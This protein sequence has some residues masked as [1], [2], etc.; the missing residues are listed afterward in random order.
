VR[1]HRY[2]GLEDSTA[3][4]AMVLGLLLVTF[5]AGLSVAALRIG[6][7]FT[8]EH[9]QEATREQAQMLAEAGVA[10]GMT[11][12][13]LGSSGSVGSRAMP[14]RY[15]DG[16]FWVSS[17]ALPG[18]RTALVAQ[19]MSNRGRAAIE[20]IVVPS[21]KAMFQAAVFSN[22]ALVLD[23]QAF[24]D[25]FDS[26]LG[27]YA[28]QL[29]ASDWN[30]VSRIG[31][32]ASN[33]DITIKSAGEVWGNATPGPTGGLYG[34]G[35]VSGWTQP[36]A[37]SITLEPVAVPAIPSTGSLVVSASTSLPA[38]DYNFTGL[39]VSTGG[40]LTV[41][42]PS[43]ILV[44]D[45]AL[46]SNSGIVFDTTNGMIELYVSGALGMAS[47][48]T[49][50]T[51]TNA[52]DVRVFLTGGPTQ[53]AIFNS[54]STFY[55]TIYAPQA[56]VQID[57]NFELFGAVSAQSVVVSANTKIHFDEALLEEFT[58][59]GGPPILESWRQVAFEDDDL[60]RWRR[61]PFVALGV[62]P[63]DLLSPAELH[64]ADPG[65]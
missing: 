2:Q 53:T 20:A 63:A 40:E 46:L 18:G 5:M 11:A 45:M 23:A 28:D 16:V 15:G 56:E 4:G 35:I 58:D 60:L 34:A 3:G 37:D 48:S 61:D 27:S 65:P 10:E 9:S 8:G 57:S 26:S 31:H 49:L 6:L 47:N 44:D 51:T 39:V 17:R 12:L 1:T 50:L 19:A 42:G 22:D 41:H 25:S 64:D 29:A 62:A 54:N 7:S 59:D 38:G 24:I 43:R 14:A 55:G 21:S 30:G 36:M 13:R 32:V 52:P 33:G